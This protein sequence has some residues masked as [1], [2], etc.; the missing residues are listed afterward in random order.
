[1]KALYIVI[2]MNV[3]ILSIG[4]IAETTMSVLLKKITGFIMAAST[5]AVELRDNIY[6]PKKLITQ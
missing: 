2:L 5:K 6:R 1:M 3:N 4:K